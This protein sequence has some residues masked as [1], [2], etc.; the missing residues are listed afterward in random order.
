MTRSGPRVAKLAAREE[1]GQTLMRTQQPTTALPE[2]TLR[3]VAPRPELRV[4]LTTPWLTN[5]LC[6]ADY[7]YRE[8]KFAAV[9]SQIVVACVPAGGDA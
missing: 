4:W 8:P 6:S 2:P 5:I 3:L 1:K 9:A 7:R